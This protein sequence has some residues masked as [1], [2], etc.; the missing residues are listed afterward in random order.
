MP[1]QD[2][3]QQVIGTYFELQDDMYQDIVNARVSLATTLVMDYYNSWHVLQ[4]DLDLNERQ[5]TAYC[6]YASIYRSE[7]KEGI[8]MLHDRDYDTLI[9][10]MDKIELTR[11]EHT[12]RLR[13]YYDDQATLR[14]HQFTEHFQSSMP[15]LVKRFQ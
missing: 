12:Q 4:D 11:L 14:F 13:L 1:Q 6:V 8:R 15:A 5:L 7:F 9:Y 10:I 3:L 2:E